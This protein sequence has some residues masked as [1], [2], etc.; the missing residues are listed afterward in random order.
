MNSA[1]YEIRWTSQSVEMLEEIADRR[2]QGLLVR[3][4]EVLAREPEKKGRPLVGPLSGYRSLRVGGQRYRIIY[5]VERSHVVVWIAALGLRR[6]GDRRDIYALARKLV[7][8]G[9]LGKGASD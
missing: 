7:R 2:I 9:L 4:A 8:A 1:G 3:S 6:E 5:R